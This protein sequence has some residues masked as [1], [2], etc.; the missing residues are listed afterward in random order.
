MREHPE[1]PFY[2]SL[3]IK[4][5]RNNERDWT[6]RRKSRPS[7]GDPQRLYA[8]YPW[9][10]SDFM[11]LAADWI[12]GFVDGEGCFYVGITEHPA[13]TVGYQV[14]PE[15]RIVQHV[16]DI[17]VLYGLKKF[18]QCGVVRQN[19]DDRYELRIRKLLC[20]EKVVDFFHKHP[21][22][23]RKKVDFTKFARIIYWMRNNEHLEL[24]G[25]IKIIKLAS[26]MN[27]G[28]QP[29]AI[30]ILKQIQLAAKDKEKAHTVLK[31]ADAM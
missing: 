27:R 3:V 24:E 15:F 10:N 28:D 14:L 6:I 21:L 20:L 5:L 30:A 19:H 8:E 26:E 4:V 7:S 13:M 9:E 16:R 23:T 11:E 1:S 25:L 12:T 2:D 17:Q 31:D 22:K 18:F 29:Q